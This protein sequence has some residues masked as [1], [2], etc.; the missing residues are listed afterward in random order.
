MALPM[1]QE[2]EY[3]N[4]VHGGSRCGANLRHERHF[5]AILVPRQSLKPLGPG[6]RS[7]RTAAVGL[8]LG[9]AKRNQCRRLFVYFP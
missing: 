4:D 3:N 5:E 9:P 8:S 7:S 6:L 2:R 1:H